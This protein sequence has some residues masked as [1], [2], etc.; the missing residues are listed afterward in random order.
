MMA[1]LIGLGVGLGV[2]A[3]GLLSGMQ[4]ERA[5]YAVILIT[6]GTYYVLFAAMGAPAAL[7]MEI[8]IA[9]GFA[10]VALVGF[11]SSRWL[12]AAGLLA[13]AGLDA[14]HGLLVINAGVPAWWPAFCGAAD[15]GLA[16]WLGMSLLL[17]ARGSVRKAEMLEGLER[18]KGIEPS[19]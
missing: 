17:E 2:G 10:L 9:T 1:L 7:G 11:K 13:H 3:L 16:G 12:V 5:F 4:R 6:V 15:V 8:L 19:S 18:A 14:S